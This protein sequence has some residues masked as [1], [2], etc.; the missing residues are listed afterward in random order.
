M[1]RH[2][3]F[4]AFR[5]ARARA[6]ADSWIV[7]RRHAFSTNPVVLERIAEL[8]SERERVRLADSLHGAVRDAERIGFS[9]SPLNRRAVSESAAELTSLADRL[10]DLDRAATPRGAVLALHLLTD[11]GSPLYGRGSSRDLREHVAVI[12]DALDDA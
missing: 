1:R 10:A 3:P 6:A 4:A 2:W 7:Q 11:G 9:A 8:T 5:R 12:H